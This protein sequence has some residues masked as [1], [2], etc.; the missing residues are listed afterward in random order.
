MPYNFFSA[1]YYESI[2]VKALDQG[3]TF[4]TMRDYFRNPALQVGKLA[5]LRHDIDA[6]PLRTNIFFGVEQKL[7]VVSSNFLLVHD[8]N[9]NPFAINVL[10]LF[11]AIEAS[12]S[13]I[14]LH[15]NYLETAQILNVDPVELLG[16]EVRALRNHFD[17]TGVA[18]HR[19]IDF[20]ANSL[21]HLVENWSCVRERFQL[22]YQ[23]Y[24]DRLMGN[25]EFVNEG[26][27]PHLSWRNRSP[28]EAICEGKNFCFSTHPHWWHRRYAFED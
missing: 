13:E 16:S 17:I 25:F 3:Y 9:Y 14:G 7:G 12:G 28:E 1:E 11:M 18:C 21:P 19:N 8:I 26:L 2:L 22:E 5:I 24:D 10:K 23:A 4:L 15:S 20:M 6:K 27:N